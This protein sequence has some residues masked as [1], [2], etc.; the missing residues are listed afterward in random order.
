MSENFELSVKLREAM[1]RLM[2]R[3]CIFYYVDRIIFFTFNIIFM[4]SFFS[5]C[6]IFICL[7]F[8]DYFYCTHKNN[9]DKLSNIDLL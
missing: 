9:L 6:V 5:F 4:M 3:F 7:I 8:G 1:Y 2:I